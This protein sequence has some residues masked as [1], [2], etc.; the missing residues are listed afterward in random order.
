MYMTTNA[1]QTIS[2]KIG[3]LVIKTMINEKP[4]FSS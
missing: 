1:K 3:N 2:K 4:M